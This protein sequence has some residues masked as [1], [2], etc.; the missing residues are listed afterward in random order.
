MNKISFNWSEEKNNLLKKSRN[1]CFEDVV[2]A[3]HNGDLL[4]VI[5]NP[6][7]NHQ[8]QNCLVVKI[9]SYSY[10]IPYAEE[11]NSL[12]LKTIYPSRKFKKLL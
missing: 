4:E 3:I 1:I 11:K 5:K 2:I 12:F 10:I 7:K 8:G 6:S 9:D